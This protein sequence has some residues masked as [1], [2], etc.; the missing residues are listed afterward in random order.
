MVL[1]YLKEFYCGVAAICI[2]FAATVLGLLVFF[3]P[4]GLAIYLG[5]VLGLHSS[6]AFGSLII[7][8]SVYYAIARHYDLIDFKEC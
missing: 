7:C 8:Y 2:L 1:K 4:F 6:I 3:A 5:D